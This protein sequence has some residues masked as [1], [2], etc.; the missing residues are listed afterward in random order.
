MRG[1]PIYLAEPLLRELYVDKGMTIKEI[2]EFLNVSVGAVHKRM[3]LYGIPPRSRMDE[4]TRAR[5]SE[6]HKGK[7]S[8]LKGTHLSD[9]RRRKLAE[10]HRGRWKSPSEFGGHK[11]QRC[12]G[13]IKVYVPTHPYATKDGYVMEH[14][15][16]MEKAIGRYITR[17]EVVHHKNHI[18]NDNRLENLQLMSFK[19][20]SALHMKE[21]WDK[22][23]EKQNA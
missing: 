8:P 12:D 16:V 4:R 9:E 15:L 3:K 14:I 5:I 11:K 2:H 21:R 19:E 23:K 13:Y 10:Y 6:A 18:R 20:H 1:K 17:E 7:P 22:R